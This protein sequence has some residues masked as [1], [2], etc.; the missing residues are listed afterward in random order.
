MK[1][2]LFTCFFSFLFLSVF[3]Q[4]AKRTSIIEIQKPMHRM[5][6]M[7]E[8]KR[9]GAHQLIY[10]LDDDRR[11][12]KTLMKEIKIIHN[13]NGMRTAIAI[14]GAA[15]LIPESLLFLASTFQRI[16]A[17]SPKGAAYFALC[18][19]PS[20]GFEGIAWLVGRSKR[21]HVH[22]MVEAYNQSIR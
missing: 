5:N 18:I 4:E 6:Y 17:S 20:I 19:T 10:L 9:I 2:S 12:P 16:D 22:R 3:S 1:K 8:G 13:R 7:Y 21:K 14:S 11:M 15:L